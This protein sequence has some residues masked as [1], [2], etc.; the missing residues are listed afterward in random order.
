MPGLPGECGGDGRLMTNGRPA[1]KELV[2]HCGLHK[3]GT[4]ALQ[5]FLTANRAVLRQNGVLYPTAGTPPGLTGQHNLAWQMARDR[6]YRSAWGDIDALFG[7]IGGFDGR[8][9]LSSEEFESSVL[10]PDRWP[11]L[12]GRAQTLGFAVQLIVYWREVSAQMQS[13]YLQKLRSGYGQEFSLAARL[14]VEEGSLRWND[15]QI[16]CSRPAM[17][18]A[19]TAVPGVAVVYRDYER[20]HGGSTV[21]DF[22]EALG[23]TEIDW[24]HPQGGRA[25]DRDPVEISLLRFLNAREPSQPG[26]RQAFEAFIMSI[27]ADRKL[28]LV[29]PERLRRVLTARLSPGE[30]VAPA[31]EAGEA[32]LVNMARVFSF[33]TQVTLKDAFAVTARTDVNDQHR[34][35]QQRMVAEWWDWIG[36]LD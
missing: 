5:N 9:I 13:V 20:L 2:V 11:R 18:K 29:V 4:T 14:A 27:F 19:L 28:K 25:N 36:G 8:V 10:H 24:Q 35:R 23:L 22:C 12:V 3:T 7:E 33:E 26:N 31:P 30:A 1:V 34:A 17:Q 16:C 21:T 32:R 6:R 15:G